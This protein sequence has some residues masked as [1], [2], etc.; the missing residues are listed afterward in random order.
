MLESV[1]K[2]GIGANSYSSLA[3]SKVKKKKK[4]LKLISNTAAHYQEQY[5]SHL[6]YT[7]TQ[8]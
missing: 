8:I 4:Q 2:T 5:H 7:Q 1:S 3:L 6:I